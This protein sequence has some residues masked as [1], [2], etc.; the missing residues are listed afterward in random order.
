MAW[1]F[2]SGASGNDFARMQ[3]FGDGGRMCAR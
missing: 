3:R 1:A 2:A